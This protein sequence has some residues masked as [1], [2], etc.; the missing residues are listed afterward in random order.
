[1]KNAMKTKTTTSLG[2]ENCATIPQRQDLID[3]TRKQQG[4]ILGRLQDPISANNIDCSCTLSCSCDCSCTLSCSCDCSCT[5][6]C[7]CPSSNIAP[8]DKPAKP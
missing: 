5:L 6:S 7:A 8:E 3:V 1:M 4:R 2:K